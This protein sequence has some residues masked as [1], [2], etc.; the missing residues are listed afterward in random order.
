MPLT[1]EVAEL[2]ALVFALTEIFFLNKDVLR[3]EQKLKSIEDFKDTI[4][5]RNIIRTIKEDLNAD[6]FV[7][8]TIKF[9][10]TKD[11]L[12]QVIPRKN[13]LQKNHVDRLFFEVACEYENIL[14][15]RSETN[16]KKKRNDI[17]AFLTE[18]ELKILEY[19]I[20]AQENML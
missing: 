4:N 10:F 13:L 17:I 14:I 18:L 19:N 9:Q 20:H 8:A 15:G 7:S 2:L 16:K 5:I 11:I 1:A 6:K 12:S 3:F